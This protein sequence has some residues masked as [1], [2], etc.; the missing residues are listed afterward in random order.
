MHR[1]PGDQLPFLIV[2]RDLMLCEP[3]IPGNMRATPI[4]SRAIFDRR[5]YFISYTLVQHGIEVNSL[6]SHSTIHSWQFYLTSVQFLQF[7]PR[8]VR[9][10][11]QISI[12]WLTM[13]CW[14]RIHS[15]IVEIPT[16]YLIKD[17]D[18]FTVWILVETWSTNAFDFP[19]IKLAIYFFVNQ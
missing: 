2:P 14:V 10:E 7:L 3:F 8:S 9:S 4:Q 16:F 5:W 13:Q 12:Y 1:T 17:V 19:L 11:S 6:I 15:K 18:L